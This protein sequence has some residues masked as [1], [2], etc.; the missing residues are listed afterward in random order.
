MNTSV[1]IWAK[2][3]VRKDTTGNDSFW[4]P[5]HQGSLAASSALSDT[6]LWILMENRK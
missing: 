6:S 3:S 1:I 5:A 2:V 4:N